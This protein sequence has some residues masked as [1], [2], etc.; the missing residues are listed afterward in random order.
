M[1]SN[2]SWTAP[3]RHDRAAVEQQ[4]GPVDPGQR[5]RHAWDSLVAGSDPDQSVEHVTARDEFDR[6]RDQLPAD[7]RGTHP[8]GA[9]RDAVGD[10]DGV[11]LHRRAADTAQ[12][13]LG[14]LREVTV[15]EVARHR[16]GP[17][18]HHADHWLA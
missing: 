5:H 3:S 7:E 15:I 2:T 16:V 14:M 12:G 4:R 13:R 18:V 8:R 11:D 17:A 6:I 9:H 10:R 1:A